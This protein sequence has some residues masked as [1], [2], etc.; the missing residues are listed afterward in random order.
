MTLEA[1]GH[2]ILASWSLTRDQLASF[3][4]GSKLSLFIHFTAS[5]YCMDMS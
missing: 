2:R 1:H 5:A 3:V 4:T